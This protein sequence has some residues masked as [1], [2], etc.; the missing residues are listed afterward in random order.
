[1]LYGLSCGILLVAV[2][3][4]EVWHPA[5]VVVP[6]VGRPAAAQVTHVV[7]PLPALEVPAR[8]FVSTL[9]IVIRFP[10]LQRGWTLNDP[11]C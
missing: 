6:E 3:A 10:G 11:T 2:A 7:R 4:A 9:F 5:V 1:M 8:R